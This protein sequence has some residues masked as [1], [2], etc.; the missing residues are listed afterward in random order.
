MPEWARCIDFRTG[1]FHHTSRS[2]DHGKK[3]DR[4]SL[5]LYEEIAANTRLDLTLPDVQR[6]VNG[7]VYGQSGMFRSQATSCCVNVERERSMTRAVVVPLSQSLASFDVLRRFTH[8][9]CSFVVNGWDDGLGG[10][11]G[12]YI[13]GYESEGPPSLD[14]GHT[15]IGSVSD[16]AAR[17]YAAD[18]STSKRFGFR[19]TR[20]RLLRTNK[21]LRR[22]HATQSER[23]A[24]DGAIRA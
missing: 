11:T 9:I 18:R 16:Q 5:Y 19:E 8:R 7:S 24:I 22:R 23:S 4:A 10:G 1:H 13:V 3:I 6:V 2:G 14:I 17:Q 21:A 20:S 12:R 15:Q